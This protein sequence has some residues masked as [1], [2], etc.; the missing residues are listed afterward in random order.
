MSDMI[1]EN[2]IG[3]YSGLNDKSRSIVR[4]NV[5]QELIE[6]A[7]SD[8]AVYAVPLPTPKCYDPMI[9]PTVNGPLSEWLKSQMEG[10]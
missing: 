2:G 1:E 5:I 6:K 3:Q 9:V 4:Q 8:G 10:E 7:E